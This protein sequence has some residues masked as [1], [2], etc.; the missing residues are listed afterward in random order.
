M[1]DLPTLLWPR[2]RAELRTHLAELSTD[3]LRVP[4]QEERQLGPASGVDQVFHVFFDD[5]DFDS[6]TEG[7]SLVSE[8]EVQSIEAVKLAMEA[9]LALVG[10][11]GDYNFVCHPLSAGVR[12]AAAVASYRLDNGI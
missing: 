2:L 8:A 1:T 4:W 11:T 12:R 9:I 6:S 3:E 10:D 7:Y 5:H